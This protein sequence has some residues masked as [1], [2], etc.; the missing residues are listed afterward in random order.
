MAKLLRHPFRSS[1]SRR[2]MRSLGLT[3]RLH[4][5]S[6]MLL[7]LGCA[8]VVVTVTSLAAG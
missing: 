7:L 4:L 5:G 2:E 3:P 6:A 8:E 1:P